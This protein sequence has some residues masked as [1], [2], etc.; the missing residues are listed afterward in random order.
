MKESAVD[1][2]L[3]KRIL[4]GRTRKEAS[5]P[6]GGASDTGPTEADQASPRMRIG[7]SAGDG[8]RDGH[9]R[10]SIFPCR[11]GWRVNHT[12][13]HR[14]AGGEG[15]GLRAGRRLCS[16]QTSRRTIFASSPREFG[17]TFSTFA[18]TVYGPS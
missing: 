9:S 8:A 6:A 12:E 14:R 13:A 7:A 16:V 2:S 17:S 3:D 11:K 10:T 15:P 18:D 5:A 4:E 1:R